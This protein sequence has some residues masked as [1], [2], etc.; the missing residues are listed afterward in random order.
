M[1]QCKVSFNTFLEIESNALNK[2]INVAQVWPAFANPFTMLFSKVYTPWMF[3]TFF[4]KPNLAIL[5]TRTNQI[6]DLY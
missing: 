4:L 6:F 3:E 2:S 5:L 1:N